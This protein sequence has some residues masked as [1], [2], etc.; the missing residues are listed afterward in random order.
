MPVLS[1]Y[2]V[3]KMLPMKLNFLIQQDGVQWWQAPK[4]PSLLQCYV[5]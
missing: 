1:A 4:G 2:M 3:S 5:A